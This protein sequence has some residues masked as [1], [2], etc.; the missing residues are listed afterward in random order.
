[1]QADLKSLRIIAHLSDLHFGHVDPAIPPVLRAALLDI[2][3]DL[4]VVSGDLTQRARR[5]QF[6]QARRFLDSLPFPRVVV[7]GNHDVPLYNVLARWLRPLEKYKTIISAD[8]EPVYADEEIVAV[9]IN[10]ARALTFKNGRINRRQ[11]DQLHER[12][13]AI[14]PGARVRIVVAHHPFILPEGADPRDLIGR[15]KMG[16]SA[17]AK[18]EVDLIL[19]G[20]LHVGRT[21]VEATADGAAG[22]SL[23]LI[24]AGTATSTRLR[25]DMNSFNVLRIAHPEL[26]IER[27]SW[28]DARAA[29]AASSLER[30]R[31]VSNAWQR[32]EHA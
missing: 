22:P 25:D 4:L 7:P 13:A 15:A 28:D 23:L 31:R 9:G 3:P 2:G 18:A 21:V 20:H 26:T 29:F 27:L 14:G 8:L 1:M 6:W 10:T 32:V 19:S 16:L 30:Y 12:L 24:Q 17:F 11:V 5:E